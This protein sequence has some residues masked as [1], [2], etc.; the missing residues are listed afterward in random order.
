MNILSTTKLTFN[1]L[2]FD[3]IPYVQKLENLPLNATF[4]M[5]D[6]LKALVSK[7]EKEGARIVIRPSGTEPVLRVLIEHKNEEKC[8]KIL[9][10]LIN[11]I[12]NA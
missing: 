5:N 6:K 12:K 4:I 11:F 7:H 10:N 9:K 8:E 2:L 1:E 3:Y